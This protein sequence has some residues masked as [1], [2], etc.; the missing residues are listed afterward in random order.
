[1]EVKEIIGKNIQKL[2]LNSKMTQFELAEKLNYSDKAV[3][4]WERGESAPEPETMLELSKIFNV[5]ID[6]FYYQEHKE[7]FLN[8]KNKVRIRDLLFTILICVTFFT[9]ST[10]VFLLGCFIDVKN[11]ATFWIAFVH[12]VPLA[13]FAVNVYF[14]RLR[15][16]LGMIIS[17]SATLWTLLASV[18]L[19]MLLYNINFWMIFLI[20]VPLQ[21]AF[22]IY[23]FIKK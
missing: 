12:A 21:A 10:S 11:A 13:S 6:Y 15:S 16:R 5:K 20:G 22:I 4:K 9:I 14:H 1:M 7:E 18:F 23:R 3:S 8:P 17:S 19:Q 2:R